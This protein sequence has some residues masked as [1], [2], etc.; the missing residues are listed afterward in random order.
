[1]IN[2]D[3]LSW[4]DRLIRTPKTDRLDVLHH[5]FRLVHGG[6]LCQTQL[7]HPQRILDIGTGTGIWAIEGLFRSLQ[8]LNLRW[9]TM[10]DS[11]RPIPRSRGYWCGPVTDSARMVNTIYVLPV[12]LMLKILQG[13]AKRSFRYR[14]YQPIG[15]EL[16]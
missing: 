7:E 10:S 4:S 12:R 15:L 11:W 5:I 2:P 9:L 8:P 3:L 13:S 6:D 1:M 14:R 16:C